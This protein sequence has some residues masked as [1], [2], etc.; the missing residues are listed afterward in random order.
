MRVGH[1]GSEALRNFSVQNIGRESVW[2]SY[3]YLEIHQIEANKPAFETKTA[4]PGL[5]SM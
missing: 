3:M 2:D 1:L 4:S 5:M